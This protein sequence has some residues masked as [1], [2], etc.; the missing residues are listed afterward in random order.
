[1]ITIKELDFLRRISLLNTTSSVPR[2]YTS[3]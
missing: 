2:R 3:S 1:M